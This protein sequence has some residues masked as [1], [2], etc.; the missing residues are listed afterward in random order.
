MLPHISGV[1][2]SQSRSPEVSDDSV[3]AGRYEA[4]RWGLLRLHPASISQG[5]HDSVDL[6]G[7]DG[8]SLSVLSH[9]YP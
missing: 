5:P 6:G 3:V 9:D 8:M 4:I 1:I 2:A 7:S